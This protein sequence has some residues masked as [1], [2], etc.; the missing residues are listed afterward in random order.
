MLRLP[1]TTISLTMTEVNDFER[2]RRFKNYLAKEDAN[3]ELP[4][5][6]ARPPPQNSQASEHCGLEHTRQ[7]V[8]PKPFKIAEL[9]E[10]FKLLSCAPRRPPK[11]SESAGN[12]NADESSV[13]QSQTSN[14]PTE[15]HVTTDVN[16]PI[17]LPPPF[18][19]ERRVV[20]DV[21]SLPSVRP[22]VMPQ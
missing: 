17:A 18:S 12:D 16:M 11:A 7:A 14:S 21:Q 1:A 3:A 8:T 10:D 9:S 4:I 5:R 2:R 20:S 13:S 15:P 6:L 19:L 22:L